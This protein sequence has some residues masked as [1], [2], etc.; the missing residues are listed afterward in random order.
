MRG[1]HVL[2]DRLMP[3]GGNIDHLVVGPG[4]VVVVDS[5]NWSGAVTIE[6]GTLRVGGHSRA[7]QVSKLVGL[8]ARV[9][10]ALTGAGM[11][12]H[13][14]TVLAL[15]ADEALGTPATYLP[16]GA[17]VVAVPELV[18]VIDALPEVCD[19]SRVDGL[20]SSVLQSFPAADATAKSVVAE[21]QRNEAPAR[22]MFLKSNVFLY[23]ETWARSGHRRL[24]L[25][26]EHGESL[27][28][29]DLVNGTVVVTDQA[30]A[31]V[32]QGILADA[33][34]GGLGLAMSRLPKIPTQLAGGRLLNR[35]GL[36]CNFLVGQHW[37]SGATNRLYGTHAVLDQ[38]I[39]DL[40]YAD[41]STGLLVPSSNE[42]LA[43]DLQPPRRYLE[44]T[45]QRYPRL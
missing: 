33:H 14:R 34:P 9:E 29:K 3:G 39:F 8:G 42:P 36:S 30:Q 10:D 19:A 4:G 15:T 21:A 5:K 24:Y 6:R 11:G 20:L 2:H 16:S 17:M 18:S 44:L 27:G 7:T 12:G 35:L 37:R 43:K 40:G 23:V 32:V 45:L 38:G 28:Y 1:W 13:V 26:D 22:A 31:A 25:N 41:L